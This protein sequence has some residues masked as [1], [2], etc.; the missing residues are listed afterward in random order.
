MKYINCTICYKEL[1][2]KNTDMENEGVL[3]TSCRMFYPWERF[4]KLAEKQEKVRKEHHHHIQTQKPNYHC[5]HGENED[6]SKIDERESQ[7]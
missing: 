2:E 6:K 3:C 4:Y 7:G 5:K 1:T